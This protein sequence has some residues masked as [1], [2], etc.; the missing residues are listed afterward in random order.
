MKNTSLSLYVYLR[1]S[2]F[3]VR[4]RSAY[5]SGASGGEKD[6][7]RKYPALGQETDAIYCP[8]LPLLA[9]CPMESVALPLGDMTDTI[10]H[11]S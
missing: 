1:P 6:R 9:S 5:F 10:C 11:V 7:S 8:L 3:Y 4:A 2:I